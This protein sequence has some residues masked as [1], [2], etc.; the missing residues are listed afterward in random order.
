MVPREWQRAAQ[1]LTRRVAMA[2][3]TAEQ[4]VSA[5]K[6]HIAIERFV[7]GTRLPAEFG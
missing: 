7:P 1:T 6:E 5:I 4:L 2:S 3:Q